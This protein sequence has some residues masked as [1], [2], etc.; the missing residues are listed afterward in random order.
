[1]CVTPSPSPV[2]ARD[3]YW[4]ICS[5][6]RHCK[7]YPEI[8]AILLSEHPNRG[9]RRLRGR[10]DS[11]GLFEDAERAAKYV[12]LSTLLRLSFNEVFDPVQLCGSR[13]RHGP[14]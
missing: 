8:I 12:N 7:S 5:V 10:R 1:M 4:F 11:S 6:P 2:S 13:E 3:K 9:T 14:S